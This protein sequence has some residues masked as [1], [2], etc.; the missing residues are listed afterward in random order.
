MIE[1]VGKDE[2]K[3]VERNGSA[4]FFQLQLSVFI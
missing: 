1:R 3:A 2:I 4:A